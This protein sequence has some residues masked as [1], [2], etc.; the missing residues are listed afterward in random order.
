MERQ[1]LKV[2]G[3]K[4][5]L[6]HPF[7]YLPLLLDAIIPLPLQCVWGQGSFP[8]QLFTTA[9][10][11]LAGHCSGRKT[12]L[13]CGRLI[14]HHLK[15]LEAQRCFHSPKLVL[16][17]QVGLAVLQMTAPPILKLPISPVRRN[18]PALVVSFMLQGV[19]LRF[20]TVVE[21][22]ETFWFL[23]CG[24]DVRKPFTWPSMW[25]SG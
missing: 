24:S 4:C 5:A 8:Q 6:P 7:S 25:L 20:G 19:L 3:E 13:L 12:G 18:F 16:M 2:P 15:A 14:S 22:V 1:T 17:K 11:K 21:V 9:V 23:K 10:L